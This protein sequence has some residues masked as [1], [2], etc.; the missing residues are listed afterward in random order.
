MTDKKRLLINYLNMNLFLPLVNSP[1]ISKELKHDLQCIRNTLNNL[2]AEGIIYYMWLTLTSHDAYTILS[3]RLLD[4]GLDKYT[5]VIN[6]VRN[7]FT[8]DWVIS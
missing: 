6:E 8:Y 2:S 3:N 5:D 4:E 1:C 7:K